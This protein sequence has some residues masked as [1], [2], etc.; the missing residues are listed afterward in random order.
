[1]RRWGFPWSQPNLPD[2]MVPNNN[3]TKKE[4]ANNGGQVGAEAEQTYCT[5]A[6]PLPFLR[7]KKKRGSNTVA[8]LHAVPAR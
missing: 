4:A 1:M 5:G 8:A 2:Q 7:K 3:P 6:A